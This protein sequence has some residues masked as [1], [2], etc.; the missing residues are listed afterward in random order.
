MD[1]LLTLLSYI[2]MVIQVIF[3]VI[4]VIFIVQLLKVILK[5]PKFRY[6]K[7]IL[8]YDHVK[9]K[10]KIYRP[11][12]R[13]I[14]RMKNYL[15][16]KR[17]SIYFEFIKWVLIDTLRGRIRLELFGIWAFCGYYG[18]GKT[19]GAI[20]YALLIKRMYTYLNIKIY[21]NFDL[22]GQDGKIESWR[23]LLIL[24]KNTIVIFDEIQST[25]TSTKFKD[26]PL[27][28]LWKLT[29]CRK[30]GLAIFCSSPVYTR[31]T[32]QLRESVDN[33]ILCKNVLSL[34]RLFT[35]S[36]YKAPEYEKHMENKLIL[37]QH[38]F[39]KLQFV[40]NNIDYNLYD[41]NQIV[42]RLDIESEAE[43]IPIKGITKSEVIKL[44]ED[45]LKQFEKKIA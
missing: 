31:M 13:K 15:I 28:L 1:L 20:H 32:V 41:T 3:Y 40:A 5:I 24:P 11:M 6:K 45:R 35:Y 38:R 9:H 17:F 27:E 44:I 18:E 25:F 42:D 29:Q 2:W 16:N 8:I 39:K 23:D 36:F 21:T 37:R 12:R 43:K 14:K 7:S 34:K 26:F 19:L 4:V 22:K 10:A 33:V 30:Q